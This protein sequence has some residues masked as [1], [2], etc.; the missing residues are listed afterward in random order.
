MAVKKKTKA[1]RKPVPKPSTLLKRAL[2]LFG[3][4]GGR[5]VKGEFEVSPGE[6]NEDPITGGRKKF[7]NGAYCSIGAIEHIDTP[8]EKDAKVFLVKAVLNA[9]EEYQE[10]IGQGRVIDFNDRPYTTFKDVRA[11]FK[12]A[13]KLAE[14]EGK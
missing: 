12:K 7:K 10:F 2:A 6:W 5:W 13:I 9:D 4:R 8:N 14:A 1:N 3:S 11:L